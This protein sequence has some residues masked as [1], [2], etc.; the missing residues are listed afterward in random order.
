MELAL[1]GPQGWT[2]LSGVG[3]GGQRDIDFLDVGIKELGQRSIGGT[4]LAT[5]V[6]EP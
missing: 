1:L 2:D 3:G 5:G 6:F 4:D